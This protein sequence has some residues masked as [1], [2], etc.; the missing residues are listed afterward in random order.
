MLE[1]LK[2]EFWVSELEL[3]EFWVSELEFCV[4]EVLLCITGIWEH[5]IKDKMCKDLNFS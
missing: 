3:L 4:S 1:K 5:N 2:L